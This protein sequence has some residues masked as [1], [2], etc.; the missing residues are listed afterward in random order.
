MDHPHLFSKIF[1]NIFCR[2]SIFL[3]LFLFIWKKKQPNTIWYLFIH[4]IRFLPKY[5]DFFQQNFSSRV[6]LYFYIF[7]RKEE[8]QITVTIL[9]VLMGLFP[10][11]QFFVDFFFHQMRWK[12]RTLVTDDSSRTTMTKVDVIFDEFSY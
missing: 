12:R 11:W 7:G 6:F 3:F 2:F 8:K 9:S 4:W 5:F 10:I 1:D